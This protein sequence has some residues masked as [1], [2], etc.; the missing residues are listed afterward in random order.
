M[1]QR[2]TPQQSS[3]QQAQ[4]G[5]SGTMQGTGASTSGA[6]GAGTSSSGATPARDR[7][8]GVTKSREHGGT[9]SAGTE[10]RRQGQSGAL[11][12]GGALVSPF[13]LMRRLSEEMDRM[14]GDFGFGGL[15]LFP[16][17]GARG[18]G[19]SRLTS[20]F[21]A[22]LPDLSEPV[23]APSVDVFQRGDDLVVSAELP[24][25]PEKDIAVEVSDGM[26]SI[27]GQRQT[28]QEEERSGTYRSERIY[29]SFYRA[30]PL[31][32]GAETDEARASFN[33][34]VLEI[35]IPHPQNRQQARSRRLEISSEGSGSSAGSPRPQQSGERR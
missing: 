8:V 18:R 23:W 10:L 33:N 15:G 30:I 35:V 11:T 28:E 5:T 29:G 31:P 4:A 19:R 14:F 22:G 16:E 9:S 32:E 13:T 24:G 2:S 25:V 12:Q 21:S 7:E 34:G 6:P 17:L 26:L 3:P 27:S 20:P 1:A